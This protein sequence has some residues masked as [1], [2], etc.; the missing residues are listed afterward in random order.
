MPK[1]ICEI[2]ASSWFY[3]KEICYDAGSHERKITDD[4]Q[5]SSNVCQN[6]RVIGR[7]NRFSASR[8]IIPLLKKKKLKF[9][10]IYPTTYPYL[11]PDEPSVA[12]YHY[13]IRLK[14]LPLGFRN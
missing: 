4:V 14:S 6:S 3:H 1:Y 8:N 9:F 12:L 2:S 13:T 7:V 11:E 5:K 10:T